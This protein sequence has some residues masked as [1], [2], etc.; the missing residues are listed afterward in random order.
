M[1]RREAHMKDFDQLMAKDFGSNN[2]LFSE[3]H[4]RD[5]HDLFIL[6]AD[7]RLRKVDVRDILMT[8]KV[9]GLDSKYEF[10]Y[11]VIEEI[12]EGPGGDAVN[13]E[14]FV[15]HLVAKIVL[16]NINSRDIHSTTM[17]EE[18]L[19]TFWTSKEKELSTSTISDIL[20]NNSDTDSAMIN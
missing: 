11:R 19:S 5:F 8:A 20:T 17:E 6:Y 18:Q 3:D 12:G 7:P 14:Q 9:L 4:L 13:F 16:F 1:A 10:V 15:Q 2:P